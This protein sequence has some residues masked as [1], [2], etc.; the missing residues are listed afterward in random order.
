MRRRALVLVAFACAVAGLVGA[1]P[2]SASTYQC[3]GIIS[4]TYQ[5]IDANGSGLHV[6]SVFGDYKARQTQGTQGKFEQRARITRPNGNITRY[7]S[8]SLKIDCQ[9]AVHIFKLCWRYRFTQLNNTNWP[10]DTE[11]CTSTWR[12]YNDGSKQMDAGWAC[13]KVL[14]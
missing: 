11:I 2:A 8:P 3:T 9:A 4:A 14:A 7:T 6:D 1:S 13:G 10:H 5:C 12:I